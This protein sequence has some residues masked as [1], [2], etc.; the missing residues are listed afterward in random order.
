MVTFRRE[1][2]R[3]TVQ[4]PG[5]LP[6]FRRETLCSLNRPDSDHIKAGI[7][8]PIMIYFPTGTLGLGGV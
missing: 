6:I 7:G 5:F 2:D 4:F 8:L 1:F 3:L